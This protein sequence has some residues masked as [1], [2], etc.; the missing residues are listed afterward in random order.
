MRQIV[1]TQDGELTYNSMVEVRALYEQ[2]FIS[3]DDLIRSEDSTRW[4]KAGT[5]ST[6]KGA[7]SRGKRETHMGV[8]VAMAVCASVALAGLFEHAKWLFISGLVFIAILTPFMVY[9]RSR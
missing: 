3:P 5:L 7:V 4:V 2:G 1:K 8:R 9:R 6:L